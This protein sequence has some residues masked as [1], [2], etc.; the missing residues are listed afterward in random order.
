MNF[1]ECCCID[2][3]NCYGDGLF[4]YVRVCLF[5]YGCGQLFYD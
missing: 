2:W 1:F 3:V 4:Q 5:V